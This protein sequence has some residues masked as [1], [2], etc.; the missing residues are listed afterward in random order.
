MPWRI[1]AFLFLVSLITGYTES[2]S[3]LRA[4]PPA[5]PQYECRTVHAYWDGSKDYVLVFHVKGENGNADHGVEDI[6]TTNSVEKK[7]RTK[8]VLG[9]VD[10]FMYAA[11]TPFCGTDA[12]GKWQAYQEVLA[13]EKGKKLDDL[14]RWPCT[15]N[16]GQPG[17]TNANPVNANTGGNI[18]PGVDEQTK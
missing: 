8:L 15:S 3:R 16:N 14:P 5:C 11:C 10:R 9:N 17:P 18:P 6:F 2:C 4:D 7:P 13:S 1:L 12:N